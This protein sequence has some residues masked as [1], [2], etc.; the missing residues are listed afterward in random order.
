M[1]A[2]PS[3]GRSVSVVV[4]CL[5]RAAHVDRLLESLSWSSLPRD[6]FEV[7]VCD[8]GGSDH[9]RSV[10]EAW[11]RRG[12][13]TRYHRVRP[14]GRPRNNAVARNAGLRLSR[15]PIVL[16]SDSDSVFVTDV[17]AEV[18]EAMVDGAFCSCGSY[19]A[20]TR[21]ASAELDA[22][23]RE[24]RLT[25]D[26]YARRANGRPDHVDSPDGVRALHGAFGCWRAALIEI[27]G[28]DERYS[29]W[30]WEDRDLLTRLEAGLG[31][32]RRF[33]ERAS[34]VHVWH[35]PQKGGDRSVDFARRGEISVRALQ[36]HMQRL[37]AQ[38]LSAVRWRHA[39]PWSLNAGDS[40]GGFAP[41]AY[42]ASMMRDRLGWPET[43]QKVF[44]AQV[45]E[46]EIVRRLGFPSLARR[47]LRF[48][49]TRAWEQAPR[50]PRW[51]DAVP[52]V[53][54][55]AV[56]RMPSEYPVA[57]L[58][59]SLAECELDL[60]DAGGAALALAA[61]A[62]CR[63]GGV[64]AAVVRTRRLIMAGDPASLSLAHDTLHPVSV[65]PFAAVRAQAIELAVLSGADDRAFDVTRTTLSRLPPNLDEFDAI[66]FHAYLELLINRS[67]THRR[68]PPDLV[69]EHVRW[70]SNVS[71]HLFSVAIRAMR[72][73][74]YHAAV[75]LLD[76]FLTGGAPADERLFVESRAHHAHLCEWLE[77]RGSQAA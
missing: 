26:D 54:D 14:P 69:A 62:S 47:F 7:I 65:A 70:T 19:R 56:A 17:M 75:L 21:A 5:N 48:T 72:S 10:A 29:E 8:D 57:D 34:V 12:L 4:P 24:R 2:T 41:S 66:L 16:N 9:T 1:T 44:R 30:G 18:V 23:R 76:R 38:D 27:D 6:R 60:G 42:R 22:L 43:A 39:G 13:P 11:S 73:G 63:D 55:D 71:E 28:Y 15:H 36:T 45:A 68:V 58:L 31:L 53:L 40:D 35:P 25:P 3:G 74:L 67:G 49:A 52:Q 33:V 50:P 61:L 32:K 77:G 59:E 46:A 37:W 64:R 20:L 51:Q